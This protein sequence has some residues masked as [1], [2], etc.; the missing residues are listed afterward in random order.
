MLSNSLEEPQLQVGETLEFNCIKNGCNQAIRFSIFDISKENFIIKCSNCE[1]EYKFNSD[2]IDKIIKF[3]KLCQAVMDA[4]DILGS[5]NVAIDV[6]GHNVK[7][8]FRL[9]M[10]RLN[11]QLD[12]NINDKQIQIKFRLMPLE[13]RESKS[14]K[15]ANG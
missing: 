6:G 5:T 9:L 12:L 14:A 13:T 3:E 7:V 4:E 11:T 10:T 15:A 2:L 8:P 1:N